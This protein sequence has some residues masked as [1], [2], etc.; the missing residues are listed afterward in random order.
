[1]NWTFDQEFNVSVEFYWAP[2]IVES[3]SDHATKHTVKRRLVHLDS[4]AKH[5]TQWAGVDVLV[6]ESYVWW[7]Y[8]PTVNVT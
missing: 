5:S 2:F 3:N 7:M 8:K 4:L 1:M 6:F